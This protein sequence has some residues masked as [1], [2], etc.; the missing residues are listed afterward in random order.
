MLVTMPHILL[1]SQ[2]PKPSK[3]SLNHRHMYLCVTCEEQYNEGYL[4]VFFLMLINIAG[5]F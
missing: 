5:S 2:R 1:L 4:Y 3:T